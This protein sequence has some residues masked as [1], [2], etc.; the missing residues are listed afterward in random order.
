MEETIMTRS[1]EAPLPKPITVKLYL[2]QLLCEHISQEESFP[3]FG[4]NDHDEVYI[5]VHRSTPRG[6]YNVERL[7]RFKDDDDYYDFKAMK[8]ATADHVGSWTNH[9]QVPVG[10]P[11]IWSGT[12]EPGQ[13]ADFLVLIAKKDNKDLKDI[14]SAIKGALEILSD[15]V[16]N[17]NPYVKAAVEAAKVLASQMPENTKYDITGRFHVS[18]RNHEGR[19]EAVWLALKEMHFGS[20][21]KGITTLKDTDNPYV[22]RLAEDGISAASF[23]FKGTGGARYEGVAACTLTNEVAPIRTYLS[24]EHDGCDAAT[25]WVTTP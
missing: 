5:R 9:D 25:I 19:L 15:T 22:E 12:L 11:M 6:G 16:A 23:I 17:L 14:K 13:H 20:G 24:T 10:A 2:D 3:V 21:K 18:I 8:K 7:P 1:S 4:N